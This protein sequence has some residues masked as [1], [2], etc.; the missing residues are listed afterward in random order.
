MLPRNA[1]WMTFSRCRRSPADL[2]RPSPTSPTFPSRRLPVSPFEYMFGVEKRDALFS[3]YFAGA[4]GATL[5]A[6]LRPDYE[7]KAVVALQTDVSAK[8]AGENFAVTVGY[9]ETDGLNGRPSGS[10]S[11]TGSL[12]WQGQVRMGSDGSVRAV[13]SGFDKDSGVGGY[14]LLPAEFFWERKL[15]KN[16]VIT[17]RYGSPVIGY[18]VGG[19]P[20]RYTHAVAGRTTSSSSSSS[21]SSPSTSPGSAAAVPV[22]VS[23]HAITAT[24]AGAMNASGGRAGASSPV[25]PEFGLRYLDSQ[26]RFSAGGHAGVA[27]IVPSALGAPADPFFPLKAWAVTGF[28]NSS[29]TVT[30][31]VQV[32]SDTRR[33]AGAGSTFGAGG[34]GSRAADDSRKLVDVDAAVSLSQPPLYELSVAFDSARQE[35]VAGYTHSLT[36]RRS[37]YNP[38]EASHVRGIFSYLDLGMEVRRQIQPPFAA[39]LAVAG[40]FQLNRGSLVKVRLGA[41][42]ASASV[43]LKTWTDPAATLCVTGVWDRYRNTTGVG[44]FLSIE[45]GGA[46]AYQKAVAGY[47][48]AAPSLALKA[49][50]HLN[51]RVTRAVDDQPFAP[52]PGVAAGTGAGAGA[53][54]GAGVGRAKF[55]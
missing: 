11:I 10:A 1:I 20:V 31:G 53:G 15:V 51:E 25:V 17:D 26:G 33:L 16:G 5:R 39:S 54:A 7:E 55:L 9:T 38:L 13:A 43:A 22:P 52:P 44:M 2:I 48:T 36:V 35:V 23:P 18:G 42:D 24:A 40:A 50:E 14:A 28:A 41:R 21:S 49:S 12:A 4:D 32:S 37:V 19:V 27:G 34:G 47:Q 46:L 30:A 6:A 45:K 29:S 8:T 3:N